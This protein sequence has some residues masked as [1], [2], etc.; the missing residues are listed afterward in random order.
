LDI[1]SLEL[2]PAVKTHVEIEL[3][4]TSAV[5]KAIRRQIC[6]LLI[7]SIVQTSPVACD[8][9]RA[10]LAYDVRRVGIVDREVHAD[11]YNKIIAGV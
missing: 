2:P 10:K 5:G 11:V 1:A 6:T 7:E 3:Q 8:M 4:P 9:R